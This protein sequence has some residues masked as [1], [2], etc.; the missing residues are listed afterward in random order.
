MLGEGRPLVPILSAV[1]GGSPRHFLFTQAANCGILNSRRIHARQS[2]K[3]D[4]TELSPY[5]KMEL[6]DVLYD[7]AQQELDAMISPLTPEQIREI[8]RLGC[9][10]GG[11]GI[12]L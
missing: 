12:C 1:F 10:D 9:R 11:G 6:A 7:T 4:M 2:P 5:Q 8:D 3:I